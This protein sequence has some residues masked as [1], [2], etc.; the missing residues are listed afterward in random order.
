MD[1]AYVANVTHLPNLLTR[2][3]FTNDGLGSVGGVIV[4]HGIHSI[5]LI[6]MLYPRG[7]IDHHCLGTCILQLSFLSYGGS[8]SISFFL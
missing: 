2:E 1:N 3:V 8:A 5:L 4:F 6:W 7:W